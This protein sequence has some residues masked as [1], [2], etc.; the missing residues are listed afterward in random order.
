MPVWQYVLEVK[1]DEVWEAHLVHEII[2]TKKTALEKALG[3]F[4]PSGRTIYTL[5]ELED[6]LVFKTVFRGQQ[7]EIKID[8][9]S[10]TQI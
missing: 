7:A 5:A 6:T 2:R 9:D 10:G 8:K 1:P 3:H 4:V